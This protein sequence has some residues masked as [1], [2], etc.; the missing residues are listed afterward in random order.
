MAAEIY[1][2]LTG[3]STPPESR[4][5]DGMDLTASHLNLASFPSDVE[6][7]LIPE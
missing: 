3:G 6:I 5:G 7:H 1:I 2:S 4:G